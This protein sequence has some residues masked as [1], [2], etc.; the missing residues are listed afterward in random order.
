MCLL[1][2]HHFS[3]THQSQVWHNSDRTTGCINYSSLIASLAKKAFVFSSAHMLL[4]TVEPIWFTHP[5]P[6]CSKGSKAKRLIIVN[7]E[8]LWI[9]ASEIVT[10]CWRSDCEKQYMHNRFHGRTIFGTQQNH[11]F[12]GSFKNLC[13]LIL[14]FFHFCATETFFAYLRFFM[15]LF[16]QKKFFYAAF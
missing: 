2:T 15:E 16:I 8:R 4:I 12:K 13:F 3:S 14:H 5:H 1:Q 10:T 6:S 11:L 9:R 7:S